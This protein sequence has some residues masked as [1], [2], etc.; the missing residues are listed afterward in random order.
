MKLVIIG[1][2]NVGS[3]LGS[4]W[5]KKGGHEVFSV[6][7]TESD[8]TQA[9][10]GALGG[11]ARAGTAAEAV[12]F[13]EMIVLAT[14][15]TAT[16]AVVRSM[17]DLNGRTILDATNPL[18]MGPDGLGLEIGTAFS[19]RESSGLGE[20]VVGV[21][22]AQHHRL[23]QHGQSSLSRGEISNVRGW[24]RYGKKAEGHRTCRCARL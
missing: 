3:T 15:W 9:L 6:L 8:K 20:G 4:A 16:E 11:K 21:Q 18:T 12:A 7:V 17:G 23:W 1:A 13:G 22:D 2:G 10:V 5:V 14:P 19:R 24:R